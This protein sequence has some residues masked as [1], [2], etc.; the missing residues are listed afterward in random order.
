M[1]TYNFIRYKE[2]GAGNGTQEWRSGA[3]AKISPR[4]A[5][6]DNFQITKAATYGIYDTSN[7]KGL[8]NAVRQ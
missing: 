2:K 6:V 4:P 8:V 1:G 5:K 7:K 3:K